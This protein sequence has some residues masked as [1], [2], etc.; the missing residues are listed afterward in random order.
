[1]IVAVDNGGL[2]FRQVQEFRPVSPPQVLQNV[3]QMR[4]KMRR[5]RRKML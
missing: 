1:L 4:A 3:P 5:L 2:P